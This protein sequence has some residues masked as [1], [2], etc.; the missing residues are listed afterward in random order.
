LTIHRVC[1]LWYDK[2]VGGLSFKISRYSLLFCN[3]MVHIC[4]RQSFKIFHERGINSYLSG[5]CY[6]H[7]NFRNFSIIFFKVVL[8]IA[9]DKLI[10][11]NSCHYL[12]AINQQWIILFWKFTCQCNS[13]I[14]LLLL[15]VNFNHV[16]CSS[17]SIDIASI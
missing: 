8:I 12:L 9:R 1:Q 16:C 6:L 14:C 15:I 7:M 2:I 11:I 17:H 13:C 4:P 10:I 3:F 5:Q